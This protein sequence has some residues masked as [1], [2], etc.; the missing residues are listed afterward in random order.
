VSCDLRVGCD[1]S[2]MG[3]PPAKLGIVYPPEG[4][5][6][7]VRTFGLATARRLFYTA[8]HFPCAELSSMGMLD[9]VCG[10]DIEEFTIDWPARCRTWRRCP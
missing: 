2:R 7:F 3:M 8:R 6:R 1:K 10:D 9:F 4:L 5:E